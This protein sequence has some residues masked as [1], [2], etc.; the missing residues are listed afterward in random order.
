MSVTSTIEW[1]SGPAPA[2]ITELLRSLEFTINRRLDGQLHGQHQGITPGWA[3]VYSRYTACQWI[4]VTD[5]PSGTYTL[6]VSVDGTGVLPDADPS[7]NAWTTTV[8]F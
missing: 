1:P 3:D 4:D 7:N 8:A 2:S 5:L 6:H